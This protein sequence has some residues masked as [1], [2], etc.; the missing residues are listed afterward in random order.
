MKILKQLQLK[1]I[2]AL[3]AGWAAFL[4]CCAVLA[5]DV[6][7]PVI[8][9]SVTNANQFLIT[10]TNG[11]SFANYELYVRPLL[12]PAWGWAMHT[13]GDP[14]QTNFIA[15]MGMANSGFF[16]IGV[17]NDWDGDGTENQFDA[18]PTNSSIHALTITIE[19]PTN[20]STFN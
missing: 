11:V 7:T 3:V 18:D 16:L 1:F 17:G 14:G 13:K 2:G 15:D 4:I 8:S 12:D 5:D 9:I 6:P 10:I 20:G 19:S